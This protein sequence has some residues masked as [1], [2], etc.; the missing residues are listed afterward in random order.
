MY[1]FG[2]SYQ[3]FA[4]TLVGLG[5]MLRVIRISKPEV[6]QEP[7]SKIAEYDYSSAGD[8]VQI[9]ATSQPASRTE[10]HRV[11]TSIYRLYIT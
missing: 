11:H 7:V 5:I 4:G 8:V 2:G 1:P 10:I 9:Y 3:S 6:R